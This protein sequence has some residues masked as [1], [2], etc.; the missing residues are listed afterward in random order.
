MNINK[1]LKKYL[2]VFMI[3]L[4]S[5]SVLISCS[6]EKIEK[7]PE[8]IEVEEEKENES[9]EKV[10][11]NE[12][13]IESD[14]SFKINGD[15]TVI[16]SSGRTVTLPEKLER[17]VPA[18]NP[19]QMVIYSMTPERLI[20]WSGMPSENELSYMDEV[21]ASLPEFG[22]FYGKKANMNLE[23]IIKAEPDLIIDVGEVKDGI[24][25]DMD[26]IQEQTGIPVIFLE[27]EIN[28]LPEMYRTLGKLLD[29]EEESNKKADYIKTTIEDAKE[30]SASIKDEDKV[31]VY[32]G[33]GENGLGTNSAGTI[34]ADVL[35]LIGAENVFENNGQKRS[36]WEEVSMEQVIE[37]N[38]EVILLTDGSI[39]DT[40]LT[41]PLWESIEAVKEGKV[42]ETPAGPY[43]WMGRPPTINRVLGIKWSGNLIYPEI[44]DYD[45]IE[46]TKEFYKLFY[47]YDLTDEEAKELM[48]KSTFK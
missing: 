8:K 34:H 4:L 25:E 36:S 5:L 7:E 42:Y 35:D 17:L 18:G 23:E 43:N 46:E 40:I 27:A 13:I 14:Y 19:A 22:T 39:Y 11:E 6:N 38:P 31:R 30:K 47:H 16:D 37:W 21:F 10:E 2:T 45:M 26:G 29:K 28:S 12:E 3:M 9:E 15:G 20:G 33:T 41:D 44:Y 32:Y 48:S 1:R 24:A